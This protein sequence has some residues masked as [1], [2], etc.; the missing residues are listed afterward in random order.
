MFDFY[1]KVSKSRK[2]SDPYTNDYLFYKRKRHK[3]YEFKHNNF[4]LYGLAH[5]KD[6]DDNFENDDY[7]I[8]LI[9]KVFYK[10][11][12][13]YLGDSFIKA[14]DILILMLEETSI[15]EKIKGN[16]TII[17]IDK[18][19]SAFK[20]QNDQIG[21]KPIYYGFFND[22]IIISN[23]L[24]HYK[25]CNAKINESVILEKLLFTY[26]ITFESFF[27]NVFFLGGGEEIF[28]NHNNVRI[29]QNFD[30]ESFVFCGGRNKFNI[31]DFVEIFNYSVIQKAKVSDIIYASLTGGFDGRA[32]V[33]TLL[34]ENFEFYTYSFGKIGGENTKVPL[35]IR[36][37]L[38]IN[39]EP[40]YLEEEYER[41]YT[42]NA[43]E[44][45]YFSDGL[46][47]SERAN[48][49][50]SFNKICSKSNFVLT[51]LIGG[52]IL[53]PLNQKTDYI[54]NLYYDLIYTKNK[55]NINLLSYL[56]SFDL[57]QRNFIIVNIN[58][59]E[60]RIEE[61]RCLI[62]EIKK[63]TDNFLYYFYDLLK[64]G[65]RRFYGS[66][67]HLE[68]I[69]V[70]NLT[71]IFDIDLLEYL[72]SSDYIYIFRNP[73]KSNP[74][75]RKNG[76]LVQAKIICNNYAQLGGIKVDRGYSPS[77]LINP[78]KQ[79]IIPFIFYKRRLRK[80][81]YEPEFTSNIW[82]RIL[83]NDLNKIKLPDSAY[84]KVKNIQDNIKNPL[85]Y[86]KD[87]NHY[88]SLYLWLNL[89]ENI[90]IKEII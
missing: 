48:Y 14:E 78:L 69:Y 8:F 16:F 49:P 42:K 12:Y 75:Y 27:K 39:Y 65:F 19:K 80:K 87:F 18:R 82:S 63:N 22:E 11:K 3:K 34:R 53:G 55:I 58:E 15:L 9:G 1:F 17:F 28:Y 47:F 37:K 71:P 62:E 90:S 36:K 25:F 21:L 77:T 89:P 2:F 84:F 44:A 5:I 23:N 61:Q 85:F 72:L 60:Q 54:N 59:V 76:R 73:F 83:Y 6:S 13:K 26:P 29:N 57:L 86:S 33:S 68:R 24:N 79:V 56:E 88:L 38:N 32:I 43:I 64:L 31:K 41:N 66:E 52:E 7:A 67:M 30:L 81:K 74:I 35:E 10:F 46:S 51:G 20:V 45:I 4:C 70:E 40:I 50:Y